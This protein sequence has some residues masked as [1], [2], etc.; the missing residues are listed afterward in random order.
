MK[1]AL[2]SVITKDIQNDIIKAIKNPDNTFLESIIIP[3]TNECKIEN[4]FLKKQDKREEKAAG[5]KK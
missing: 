1:P 4:C 3:E 5:S 2:I